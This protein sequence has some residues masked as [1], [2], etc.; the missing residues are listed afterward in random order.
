MS[1]PTN[2]GGSR[3][4][5]LLKR[6]AREMEFC[7][8]RA[9]EE[10]ARFVRRG[11]P[12]LI[13]RPDDLSR[14]FV[15]GTRWHDFWRLAWAAGRLLSAESGH[16]VYVRPQYLPCV[17]EALVLGA[18][19]M[20]RAGE[21]FEWW[22]PPTG[23]PADPFFER[24]RPN[25]YRLDEIAE[26]LTH[27]RLVYVACFESNQMRYAAS[28]IDWDDYNTRRAIDVHLLHVNTI[29]SRCENTLAR[30]VTEHN[31]AP[32]MFSGLTRRLVSALRLERLAY[33]YPATALPF[34]LS[35][36]IDGGFDPAAVRAGLARTYAMAEGSPFPDAPAVLNGVL[37]D[38][39]EDNEKGPPHLVADLRRHLNG[40]ACPTFDTVYYQHTSSLAAD[41]FGPP[42]FG[43]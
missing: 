35:G 28:H 7:Y 22:Y 16:H 13:V 32:T 41:L 33:R 24:L 1:T 37:A 29:L 2:A 21:P 26:Q 43:Y 5:E 40:I 36:A 18:D 4:R 6:M 34:V 12:E 31:V 19:A 8:Y 42:E 15:E 30:I 11:G 20:N 10:A 25:L 39:R 23:R 27:L 17:V 9:D 38:H 3:Q 14:P